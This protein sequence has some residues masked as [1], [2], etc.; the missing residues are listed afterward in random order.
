MYS[1]HVQFRCLQKNK[2]QTK[3]HENK[4]KYVLLVKIKTA[5]S[6]SRSCSV[7][8]RLRGSGGSM[9]CFQSPPSSR[10]PCGCWQMSGRCFTASS[11][12]GSASAPCLHPVLAHR[13]IGNPLFPQLIVKISV[14][15]GWR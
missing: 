8:C 10:C 9:R 6:R 15:L 3:N 11:T 4:P 12:S 14:E 1:V 7:L 5:R 13:I 2:Q